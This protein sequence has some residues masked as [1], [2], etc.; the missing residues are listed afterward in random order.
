MTTLRKQIGDFTRLR[1]KRRKALSLWMTFLLSLAAVLACAALFTVFGYVVAKGAPHLSLSFF[2]NLPKPIGETGGG[3]LNALVGSALMVFLASLVGIPWGISIGMYLSEYG[4]GRFAFIVRFCCEMLSSVPSIVIGLFIYVLFV[5]PM[6]RFSAIAGSIALA[7][8]MVPLVARNTEELLKLVPQHIREAGLALGI[9]RWKVTLWIVLR[10]S[11]S[12]ITTGI[13]L[14]IARIAG[15]T[16]PLLF[17]ALNNR[18]LSWVP[19]Q[20]MA[21]LPVQIY[22]YAIA[23]F[24][25]WNRLAWSGAFV[26][27]LFVFVL[28]MM[29][30]AVLK[31]GRPRG[32]E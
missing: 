28:N 31:S 18:F 20:P 26:L 6:H 10:G 12:G 22:T 25:E 16:A 5:K 13:M 8:I 15:E 9:P 7:L 32:R 19:D 24:E 3:M 29:T 2:T 21:S 27:I 11:L 17:T 23:P 4:R 14:G 1:Y 30:R